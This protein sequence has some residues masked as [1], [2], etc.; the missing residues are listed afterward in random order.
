ME[1]VL[2]KGERIV[3]KTDIYGNIVDANEL[4]EK[5]SGYKKSEII[6]K[7]HNIIRHQDM[8]RV[9]FRLLWVKLYNDLEINAFVKNRSKNG[10][11]YW[12]YAT[13]SPIFN[14]TTHQKTG[15]ISI[16]KAA[17]PDAI[18]QISQIYDAL[19]EMELTDNNDYAKSKEVLRSFVVK[20]SMKF[21]D[22]MSKM[23]AQGD[24]YKPFI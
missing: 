23:Q 6:G 9:V 17:N 14:K 13:A 12:V 16:R 8:P 19:K 2:Q 1:L 15:Y 18:K 20:N 11:Y 5:Y 4:F 3:S 22:I 7:P 10:D 21:K 24:L